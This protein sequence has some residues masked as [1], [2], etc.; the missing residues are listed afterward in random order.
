MSHDDA[1]L[2]SLQASLDELAA[3][4]RAARQR[5]RRLTASGLALAAACAS[6]HAL[7]AVEDLETDAMVAGT[8]RHAFLDALARALPGRT[9]A[10]ARDAAL[11]SV[12]ADAPWRATCEAIDVEQLLDLTGA[13][14][15][16]VT[17]GAR[18][19]WWPATNTAT[20]DDTPAAH[21][22]YRDDPAAIY[23]TSD[24]LVEPPSGRWTVIDFKGSM[25]GAPAAE[26]W[27]VCWYA[28]ALA[29]REG[30]ELSA[31]DVA[32]I[33]IDEDG[34]LSRDSAT[35]DSW[36][37]EAWA[38]RFAEVHA[39]VTH[40]R[41]S[42]PGGF[43]RVGDH[44]SNCPAFRVCPAMS[45]LAR[46]LVMAPPSP[47]TY[48]ALDDDDAG[49]AWQRIALF[50]EVLGRAKEALRV[51]ALRK[52]LP[53]P[54]GRWLMPVESTRRTVDVERALPVLRELVGERAEAIV[55]RSLSASAIDGLARELAAAGGE[56]QKAVNE[57]VWTAL[58][59][60]KAARESTYVQLRPRKLAGGA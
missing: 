35:L 13:R 27:Q 55:E 44:C 34:S 5:S 1:N 59:E 14:E 56:K 30:L 26:H 36:D 47:E 52:G 6:S 7:P 28:L 45:A 8:G 23:G 20:L 31:V 42:V 60:A 46:E 4:R 33:Y 54:D 15:G 16:I 58:R 49:A 17:V 57:R 3:A 41:A 9:P 29:R 53:L 51:R 24:W 39:R 2:D 21:R 50:E 22:E 18:H 38:Q 19:T 11:A 43:A 25:R 40:A 32:L 48:P 37:I 12:P 10:E